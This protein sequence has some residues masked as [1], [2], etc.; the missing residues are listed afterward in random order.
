MN[1]RRLLLDPD[2]SDWFIQRY[3]LPPPNADY[4]KLMSKDECLQRFPLKC[5]Q[6]NDPDLDVHLRDTTKA[7][8]LARR[9]VTVLPLVI[10]EASA[11]PIPFM[12]D[13][14]APGYIYMSDKAWVLMDSL[15][16]IKATSGRHAR[17][18]MGTLIGAGGAQLTDPPAEH[19]PSLDQVLVSGDE[20]LN[21]LGIKAL[22]ELELIR[23]NC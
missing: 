6:I 14:G 1:A 18:I 8:T 2:P 5:I 16:L 9:A 11:I 7:K 13:T 20:R 22:L 23:F 4:F 21:I 19:V 3:D 15:H 12:L 17:Q 10:G